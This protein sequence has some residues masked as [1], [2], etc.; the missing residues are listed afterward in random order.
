M[1][2]LCLWKTFSASAKRNRCILAAYMGARQVWAPIA[3][4]AL[5]TVIVFVP[6]LMLDLPVGQLF[7]EIGIAI[8]VSVLISMVV[9]VTVIPM[10]AAGFWS[11]TRTAIKNCV[12]LRR[13]IGQPPISPV[14]FCAMSSCGL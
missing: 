11:G 1:R 7:R 10:L 12:P 4:S 14:K 8:S 13:L 3:G 2:Q 5:T 6:V 9:S